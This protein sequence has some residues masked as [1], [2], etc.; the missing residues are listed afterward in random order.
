MQKSTDMSEQ[1]PESSNPPRIR[2]RPAWRGAL[3]VLLPGL[4]GC[5][6]LVT[7]APTALGWATLLLLATLGAAAWAV[8][9]SLARAAEVTAAV[10]AERVEGIDPLLG[11]VLPVWSDQIELARSQTEIAINDLSLR[12]GELSQRLSSTLSASQDAGGAG[13]GGGVVAVLESSGERLNGIIASLRAT[14]RERDSLLQEIHTLS[15][16]TDQLREMAHNVSSIAHQTNLLAINAAIEAARAGEVGRGFA[17]VAAEVRQLSQRS[18]DTGKSIDDTVATVNR[19]IAQTLTASRQFAQRDEA[20]TAES[21]QVIQDVLGRFQATAGRL[22][23]TTEVM[24]QESQLIQGEIA[25]VLV[26]LQFQDRTS[27]VLGHVRDDIKKLGRKL[28]DASEQV[29]AG[30]T[31]EALDPDA[32]LS[33]LT[34]TYTMAEQHALHDGANPPAA[35]TTNE[36]T[37]F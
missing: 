30:Q 26:G 18:S 12:F 25:N 37:F 14:L 7:L 28:D 5:G 1:F 17:V 11:Q 6:A 32:W 9:Q 31:P 21:E 34:S 35:A 16:F 8:R 2:P 4:A 20:I 36:I 22:H 33:E 13:A 15:R 19:A 29:A 3:P 23:E 27:Q 24:R 10:R